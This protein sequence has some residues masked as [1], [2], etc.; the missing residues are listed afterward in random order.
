MHRIYNTLKAGT[1]SWNIRKLKIRYV[2]L[3]GSIIK[4][5]C[6]SKYTC[7]IAHMHEFEYV[8]VAHLSFRL[9]P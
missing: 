8:V 7:M 6:T 1:W 9:S 5:I 2:R 4:H 3:L